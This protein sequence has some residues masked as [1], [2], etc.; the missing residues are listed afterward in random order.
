M[1]RPASP[2][3]TAAIVLAVGAA[4]YFL[5]FL[6]APVPG[7]SQNRLE[8]LLF[9]VSNGLTF[10]AS[11]FGLSGE[12]VGMLDR[13]PLLLGAG[14][15]LAV[16][17]IIG[18]YL[19]EIVGGEPGLTALEQSVFGI[20]VGLNVVSLNT[21]AVGLAGGLNQPLLLAT[22]LLVLVGLAIFRWRSRLS[23]LLGRSKS[24][25]SAA[26]STT[27]QPSPWGWLE[28]H[29]GWL[30]APFVVSIVLGG[31]LPP[32]DFDVREYHLQT[33]KE[34]SQAGR[35]SFLPHNVYANMPLGAEAPAATA[36]AF[37]PGR[38]GWWW[39]AL[40]G[41]LIMATSAPLT[42]LA[43]YAA[44]KRFVSHVAGVIAAVAY[45][46]IPWICSVA[47][48]GLNEGP[49]AMYS[50]LAV[51]AVLLRF[52]WDPQ[53]VAE[54]RPPGV[55]R[56]RLLLAG[57]LAGAAAACKYPA[58]VF[59][60][61]PLTAAVGLLSTAVDA[62]R[63][64]R[65]AFSPKAVAWF[66]LAVVLGGGLWY[67]KNAVLTG[68]P[69]YP[70][71]ASTLGGATRTEEKIEQWS[72]AHATPPFSIDQL[73]NSVSKVFY[74][75]DWHSPVIWPLCIAAALAAQ[76][77]RLVI[78]LVVLLSYCV[79]VWWLFTHRIDRF[80]IPYF[81]LAALLCGIGATARSDPW[82]R[83]A[84]LGVLLLGLTCNFLMLF[85]PRLGDNRYFAAMTS[86]RE[87][88]P[89]S[90]QPPVRVNPIHRYLNT[91]QEATEA[92]LL[93]GD[94]EPFDLWGTT[95][96][97]TVFD[98]SIFEQMMQ[99]RTPE[100]QRRRLIDRRIRYVYVKWS[101]IKRY[102]S[103]G[104]YGFTDYVTEDL[105]ANMVAAGLLRPLHPP[106]AAGYEQLYE[107]ITAK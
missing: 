103:P 40:I 60:V 26:P 82:W 2:T 73:T 107:V 29:G 39:G 87:D 43:L 67:A 69:V 49:L 34:W 85:S 46:S 76:R 30:A 7:A 80:W 101:D 72:Q 18:R 19:L 70:L 52:D 93:V 51:Y 89:P 56:G 1:R 10:F 104:N 42:A 84:V 17:L 97:N 64:W 57:F 41:K 106:G 45:V 27:E 55:D 35:V 38:L 53:A 33:P 62:S 44:G 59:T 63:R 24:E 92:V 99:G 88:G 90:D 74:A 48:Q 37:A 54:E 47:I 66:L 6:T 13:I 98:H 5:L 4:A 12:Q 8:F 83:R 58:V 32:V 36:M 94:A 20:A 100:Q 79:A 14:V 11:W 71:A 28:S 77:R 78:A 81:P 95:I 61:I 102:R 65:A 15:I 68:N 105:L 22:P 3:T 25:A 91:H 23:D 75:S 50:F 9:V 86:L 96:Y 31:M 16:A 21:L